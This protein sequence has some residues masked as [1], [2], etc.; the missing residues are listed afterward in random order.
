MVVIVTDQLNWNIIS[1]D[2]YMSS[3]HEYSLRN[4]RRVSY[5][6]K[7]FLILNVPCLLVITPQTF[8]SIH[9]L[10]LGDNSIII[11]KYSF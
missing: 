6:V 9:C 11:S 8:F 1:S 7:I 4:S 5:R 3:L 2:E 10:Q